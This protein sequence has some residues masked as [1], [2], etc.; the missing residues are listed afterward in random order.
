MYIRRDNE[1]IILQSRLLSSESKHLSGRFGGRYSIVYVIRCWI[2][3]KDSRL[4]GVSENRNAARYTRMHQRS[5]ETCLFFDALLSGHE[6]FFM[7]MHYVIV[8]RDCS[9]N[10]WRTGCT[11]RFE[12]EAS[13]R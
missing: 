7:A 13:R 2:P 5:P 11:R 12:Y 3:G 1:I 6:R 9:S 8:R 10:T 4:G